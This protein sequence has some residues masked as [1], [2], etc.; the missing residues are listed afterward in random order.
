MLDSFHFPPILA[1]CLKEEF[2]RVPVCAKRLKEAGK[3]PFF[4]DGLIEWAASAG[5]RWQGEFMSIY[6][7]QLVLS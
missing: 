3:H 6:L 5:F 7:P 1:A 4:Q 2:F